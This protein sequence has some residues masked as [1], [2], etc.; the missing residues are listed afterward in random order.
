MG[1]LK[2]IR[3]MDMATIFAGPL[4]ATILGDFGADVIKIEHP[5]KGDPVRSHGPSKNGIPLWWAMLA[6]NKRTVGL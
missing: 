5:V 2:G 1:P 6:R 4:A 3:V